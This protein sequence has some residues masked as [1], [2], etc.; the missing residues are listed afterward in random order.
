MTGKRRLESVTAKDAE[1]AEQK[2]SFTAEAAEEIYSNGP[3][4][5]ARRQR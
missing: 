5:R 2:K 3:K 1:G 4:R